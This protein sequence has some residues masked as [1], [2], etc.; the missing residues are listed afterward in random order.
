LNN[1]SPVVYFTQA[2][3]PEAGIISATD[4]SDL[5]A[6]GQETSADTTK[7]TLS[8]HTPNGDRN[9]AVELMKP[10]ISGDR[11]TYKVRVILGSIPRQFGESTLFIDFGDTWRVPQGETL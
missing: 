11:V 7:G 1:V 2:P 4:F 10:M 9:V 3:K 5:W 8:I 6:D